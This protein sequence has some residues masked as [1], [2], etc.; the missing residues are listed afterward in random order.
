MD[1]LTQF[2]RSFLREEDGAQI[3]E[4]ALIIAAV[5]LILIVALQAL[6]NSDFQT[7]VGKVGTC[8]TTSVC[9]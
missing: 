8:L 5:S 6:N 4:Y 7:F 9:S 3:V 1:Q 2:V